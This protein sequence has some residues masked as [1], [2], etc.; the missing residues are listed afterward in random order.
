M[1]REEI[2]CVKIRNST[3][4]RCKQPKV[5]GSD[6]CRFHCGFKVNDLDVSIVNAPNSPPITY[7]RNKAYAKI[8]NKSLQEKM[9]LARQLDDPMDLTEDLLLMRATIQETLEN[10]VDED[11]KIKVAT[12]QSQLAKLVSMVETITNIRN[13]TA[14][15]AAEL[16]LVQIRITDLFRKY[17][18]ENKQDAFLM[19]LEQLFGIFGGSS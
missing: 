5:D 8:V 15:T 3:G 17:V 12:L 7:A 18:P 11:G 19:E 16:T 10:C 2:Q 4:E 13:T 9:E 1:I 6:K 14:V